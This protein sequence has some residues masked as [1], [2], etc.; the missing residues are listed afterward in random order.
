VNSVA[1]LER[2]RC[3][4]CGAEF[5]EIDESAPFMRCTRI[6]CGATFVIRQ[7]KEFAKAEI[8]HTSDIRNLRQLLLEAAA[9]NDLKA[10]EASAQNIRMWVPDDFFAGYCAALAQKKYG[11]V[12]VYTDFLQSGHEMTPEERD[13]VFA[14]MLSHAHFTMHDE[15]AVH[16]YIRIN[17]PPELQ[18]PKMRDLRRAVDCLSEEQNLLAHIPLC[19]HLSQQQR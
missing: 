18:E 10:M 13:Q 4:K 15:E 3:T 8:D 14:I 17:Y 9:H 7:A 16:T 19:I 2:I 11:R 12:R 1:V 5:E 6:G